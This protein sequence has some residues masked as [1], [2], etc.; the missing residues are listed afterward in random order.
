MRIVFY[1]FIFT[2]VCI[3]ERTL[4]SES[5]E[6]QNVHFNKEVGKKILK[7]NNK[8]FKKRKRKPYDVNNLEH[9]NLLGLPRTY[10][11]RHKHRVSRVLDQGDCGDCF[12][13]SSSVAIEYWYAHLRKY[14]RTPPHFSVPELSD[15]TSVNDTPNEACEG[16]LMEYVFE[17]GKEYA[18]SFNREYD[19]KEK[20]TKNNLSHLKITDYEVQ[21][22]E[23]NPHIEHHM[24]ALLMKYG[25]LSVGIDTDNDYID[26]YER[27][28]F[29]ASKCGKDIDHA[30]AIVGFTSKTWIVKNS[31][32]TDWGEKGY[33]HLPRNKNACGL[34]EYVSYIKHA[35]IIHEIIP[36]GT[37][38]SEDPP[39]YDDQ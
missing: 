24:P 14:G 15:C 12:A 6:E 37:F 19:K 22:I 38:V 23:S 4:A 10:D 21:D 30:V 25:P 1:I 18:L 32:G 35:E 26:N 17:Y 36:T 3:I 33:F 5:L 16:G 28:V 20:C 9:V 29:P 34:A 2:F 39:E 27:G 13:Y 8:A 7:R 31:W 11:L